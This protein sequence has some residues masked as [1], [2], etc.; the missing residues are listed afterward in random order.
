MKKLLFVM[1]VFLSFTSIA[2]CQQAYI[3]K[4]DY[5]VA[6]SEKGYEKMINATS[7]GDKEYFKLLLKNKE[8]MIIPKDLDV[9]L[10]KSSFLGGMIVVRLKGKDIKLY[11]VSEAMKEKY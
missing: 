11:T 8:I 1:I 10:I 4:K 9:H 7:T 5:P 2:Y 3:L 6:F